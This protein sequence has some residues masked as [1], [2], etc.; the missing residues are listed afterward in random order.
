MVNDGGSAFP[1]PEFPVQ[2]EQS[3]I[4]SSLAY[5]GLSN[6]GMTLRQWYA[7]QAMA[8]TQ[9]LNFRQDSEFVEHCFKIADAM[10]AFEQ[11]EK[12]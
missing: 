10:I 4:V 2:S 1:V 6:G 7:G 3:G 8:H 5:F 9:P 12:G 11:N